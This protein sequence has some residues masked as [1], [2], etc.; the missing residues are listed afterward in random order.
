VILAGDIG[1]TNTRLA[2]F[3]GGEYPLRIETVRTAGQSLTALV[4]EFL[5]DTSA[6]VDAAAFGVAGTI[7]DNTASGVNLPWDVDGHEVAS[8]LGAPVA[9]VNDLHAN[10]RGV[11]ALAPHDV[12]VLNPGAA[13]IDGNRVVLSAGTGLGEAGL[14]WSGTR[15]HVVATEGGHVDFAPRSE[16]EIDLYRFLADEY[17]HVS[18]ERILSGSGLANI[19]RFL[20]GVESPPSPAEITAEALSDQ[21]SPSSAALD[22]FASIYGARAGNA[23]LTSMATG[24]VF[25]GG[26]IPPKIIG[27]LRDGA[28]MRAFV[29]KG[30]FA[31]LLSRIPVHV[32]L[33]DHAALL[34]AARIAAEHSSPPT[35]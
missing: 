22:L 4:E 14:F 16:L 3:N 31:P 35:D 19:Y 34:G 7:A 25:L 8:S 17:G 23:A 29:D 11:E 9:V 20:T 21:T 32:I 30:R 10:A 2:L 5:S 26:G 18:Y 15:Y 33:N 12:A 24:G 28:F 27:R 1:G 6:S 13:R